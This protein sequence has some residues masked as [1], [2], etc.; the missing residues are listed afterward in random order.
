MET[1]GLWSSDR[2]RPDGLVLTPWQAKKNGIWDVTVTVILTM[3]YL[4]STLVTVGSAAEQASV[5]KEKTTD[6][7]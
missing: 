6:T 1:A 4:S 2:K 5:R 3:S 7:T